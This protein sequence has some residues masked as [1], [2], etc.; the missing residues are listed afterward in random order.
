MTAKQRDVL[1]L[2]LL[3]KMRDSITSTHR[4]NLQYLGES[5]VCEYRDLDFAKFLER[6]NHRSLESN[7]ISESQL[8]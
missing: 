4:Y 7:A 3:R 5:L 8:K 6:L 2:K 1:V